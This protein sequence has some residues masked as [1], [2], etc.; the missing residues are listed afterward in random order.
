[1]HR[2]KAQH[3]PKSNQKKESF[4]RISAHSSLKWSGIPLNWIEGR[5]IPFR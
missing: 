5:Y 4:L 2:L 1:M 3:A